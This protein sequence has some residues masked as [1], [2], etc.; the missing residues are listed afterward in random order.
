ME[1]GLSSGTIFFN[2]TFLY[3]TAI[4]LFAD[5]GWPYSI[6]TIGVAG[7]LGAIEAV[8]THLPGRTPE[9]TDAFYALVLGGVLRLLASADLAHQRKDAAVYTR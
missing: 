8:Q 9:I 3:G 7:L 5:A 1:S 2:K 6:A 4:R